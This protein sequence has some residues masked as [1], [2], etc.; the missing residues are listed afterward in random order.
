MAVYILLLV[1]VLICSRIENAKV[2]WGNKKILSG[3]LL[4]LL[5]MSQVCI[6][7]F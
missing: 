5:L 3:K 2:F 6:H 7:M 4:Y 1:W